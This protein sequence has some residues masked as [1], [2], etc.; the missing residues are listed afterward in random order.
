MYGESAM[1]RRA[2]PRFGKSYAIRLDRDL[3]E[4]LIYRTTTSRIV[5]VVK[6][7]KA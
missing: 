3:F 5:A 7:P 1:E 6:E 4:V 2:T